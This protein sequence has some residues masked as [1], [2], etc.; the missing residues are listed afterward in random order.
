[1]QLELLERRTLLAGDVGDVAGVLGAAEVAA[2]S[3]V[4]IE[5]DF[6]SQPELNVALLSFK[7]AE[8]GGNLV[9]D[10]GLLPEEVSEIAI[11]SFDQVALEGGGELRY[12]T[13]SDVDKIRLDEISVSDGLLASEVG[14]ISVNQ[15]PTIVSLKGTQ[16][17]VSFSSFSEGHVFL[18]NLQLLILV[19]DAEV[20]SLFIHSQNT[21]Q[22]VQIS[23]DPDSLSL[24]GISSERVEFLSQEV[25]FPEFTELSAPVNSSLLAS[26]QSVFV[27]ARDEFSSASILAAIRE[28]DMIEATQASGEA[29]EESSVVLD[30]QVVAIGENEINVFGLRVDGE[31]VAMMTLSV[32]NIFA[33]GFYDREVSQN[34]V[35][36]AGSGLIAQV[37]VPSAGSEDDRILE[38][39]DHEATAA[40]FEITGLGEPFDTYPVYGVTEFESPS[41]AQ[42]A[43]TRVE[44]PTVPR[45][46]LGQHPQIRSEFVDVD[47]LNRIQRSLTEW[48]GQP[49]GHSYNLSEIF[50]ERINDEFSPG[51]RPVFAE[52]K[53]PRFGDL[54]YPTSHGQYRV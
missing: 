54:R 20:E 4:Q 38:P 1:M 27:I 40:G 49:E 45:V 28:C 3:D 11:S 9:I 24:S 8:D 43:E 18:S 23:F 37:G 5:I 52:L 35:W 17:L 7:G 46:E 12:L 15:L 50:I 51:N 22:S 47:L 13:V 36:I 31:G 39:S 48:L 21:T 6:A 53:A 25:E 32:P 14:F 19:T 2:I 16:S 29:A 42:A 30:F 10:V 33:V 34:A 44:E 26:E 41:A